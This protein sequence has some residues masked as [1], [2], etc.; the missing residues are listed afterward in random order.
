MSGSEEPWSYTLHIPNDPRAVAV[1]RHTLRL[2]L[3]VHGLPH[4]ASTAELL[5]TELVTNAVT[6]T[7]G[8]VAIRLCWSGSALRLGAWDTDPTPPSPRPAAVDSEAEADNGRG[9]TLVRAC[10]DDWGWHQLTYAG[11]YVWCELGPEAA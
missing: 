8:P 5:G 3:T 9:L 11:K 7:K 6:H 10:S 1:C 2:V 4:L